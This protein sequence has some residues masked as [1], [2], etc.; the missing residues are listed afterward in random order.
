[1]EGGGQFHNN[2]PMA[3]AFKCMMD[4]MERRRREETRRKHIISHFSSL[5]RSSVTAWAPEMVQDTV[6][7]DAYRLGIPDHRTEC[8]SMVHERSN[9]ERTRRFGAQ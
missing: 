1:M 6:V 2:Q 9:I 5:F 8:F 7:L 3:G 4:D